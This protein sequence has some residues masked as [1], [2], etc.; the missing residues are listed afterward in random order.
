MVEYAKVASTYDP[1]LKSLYKKVR[2]RR[3]PEAIIPKPPS[4]HQQMNQSIRES[5]TTKH[6]ILPPDL[7]LH[8]FI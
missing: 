1:R 6:N 2:S 7:S 3:R 5:T 4:M 8:S